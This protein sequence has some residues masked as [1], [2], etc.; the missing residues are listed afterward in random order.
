MKKGSVFLVS[1]L[2]DTTKWDF[3]PVEKVV[4]TVNNYWMTE[5]ISVLWK[6]YSQFVCIYFTIFHAKAEGR[7]AGNVAFGD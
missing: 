4:E 6:P 1:T 2:F 5:K 3:Y 7:G